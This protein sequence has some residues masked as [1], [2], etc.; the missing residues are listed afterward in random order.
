M[1]KYLQ[2]RGRTWYA[3]LEVPK[4]LRSVFGKARFKQSL[5]TESRTVAERKMHPLIGEWKRQ[6]EL[7]RDRGQPLETFMAETERFGEGGDVLE[8]P[9]GQRQYVSPDWLKSHY[10]ELALEGYTEPPQHLRDAASL[11]FSGKTLLSRH[12]DQFIEYEQGTERSLRQKRQKIERLTERFRFAEDVTEESLF[13]WVED[14]LVGEQGMARSTLRNHLSQWRRFWKWLRRRH[15][16]RHPNPFEEDVCK[17]LLQ[18]ATKPEGRTF[19][20]PQEFWHLLSG[21]P[22]DDPLHSLIQLA[23]YTGLRREALC[24][25][26]VED[27]KEDRLYIR[28]RKYEPTSREFPLHSKLRPLVAR[29]VDQ[30]EDGLLL[31]LRP[32][33]FGDYSNSIGNRFS[34]Y[35][36][37]MGYPKSKTLHSFRHA[38]STQLRA[39]GT[40][41]WVVDLMLGWS[42]QRGST[43]LTTYTHADF[44]TM[45]KAI[46]VVSYP[47]DSK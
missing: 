29:L 4:D 25:L 37:K 45:K 8:G 7:A 24:S 41:D 43:G 27:V 35:K 19:W 16:L 5:K 38:V 13:Q 11:V 30:S 10:V 2:Q 40:P 20:E 46:E 14:D 47:K 26:R 12:V 34:V 22:E 17:E 28:K 18:R 33:S 42:V 23:A 31:P 9:E 15:G 39:N 44:E 1:P 32:D 21:L 36:T 6:L 3:V